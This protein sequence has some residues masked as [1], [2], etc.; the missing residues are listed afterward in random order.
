MS[1]I[2]EIQHV[3]KF[4]G[5]LAANSDVSFEMHHGMIMGLIG[6]NG[7]GKTTFVNL[8][9]G[10]VDATEGTVHL[11]DTELTG[12]PHRR[13]R[14]GVSRT[15]QNLRVF[16]ALSVRENVAVADLVA[17]DH[18]SHRP[19]VG[20]DELLAL[21]GLSA[22]A[23]RPASTLDY[24]NQR[25]LEIARAA[26]LRPDYLLLDEPTSGMSSSESLEMVDHVR[27]VALAIGAGVLVIDHDLGF[28]TNICER[29]TVLDQGAVL[30]EGTPEEI[31]R[32]P[33]VIEAYLGSSHG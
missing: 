10:L 8:L 18:R 25:R 23:D 13:A 2:L 3:S 12:A 1:A 17:H 16:P 5:G 6:P 31:Q 32:D 7:A 20:V 26:A 19:A 28:I 24:G 33:R 14:A 21:A 27:K 30:A 15:F 29:I 22:L 4:F 11:G 9:T